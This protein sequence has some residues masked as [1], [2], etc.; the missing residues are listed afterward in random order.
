MA[1]GQYLIMSRV[2]SISL[3]DSQT[4]MMKE[5]KM[6]DE[7]SRKCGFPERSLGAKPASYVCRSMSGKDLWPQHQ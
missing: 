6:A 1:R 4:G 2:S 5:A 3:F 7:Y